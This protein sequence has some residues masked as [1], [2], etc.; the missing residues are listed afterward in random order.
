V[1]KDFEP[2]DQMDDC[3]IICPHCGYSVQAEPEDSDEHQR[4]EECSECG[5][6]FVVWAE[7]SVTYHTR[8]KQETKP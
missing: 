7:M 4:T 1:R 5:K 8:A 6:E 2:C 3:N